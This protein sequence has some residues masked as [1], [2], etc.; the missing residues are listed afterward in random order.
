LPNIQALSTPDIEYVADGIMKS[1]AV[2]DLWSQAASYTPRVLVNDIVQT[3]GVDYTY[4]SEDETVNFTV[5]PLVQSVIKMIGGRITITVKNLDATVP[6]ARLSVLPGAGTLFDDIGFTTYSYVQTLRSP[7]PQSYA[8]FGKSLFISDSTVNLIVGAPDA[9]AISI[10]TFDNGTTYFDSRSTGFADIVPQSGAV[11]TFDLLPSA[12]SSITNPGKFV[13]GQQLYDT[14]ISSLDQFGTAVDYT[15]GVLLIGSPGE[16]DGDSGANYGRIAEFR[17]LG[18]QPAWVEIRRQQP[19]VNYDLLNTVFMYD[20]VAGNVKQYFDFFNPLQGRLLGAVRQNLDYIGAIDPAAYNVGGINNYGQKWGFERVGQIWWDTTEARFIDPNQDDIVYASRRWGQLFP[21]SSVNVYQWVSSDVPPSQYQGPGQVRDPNSYVVISTLTPQGLFA[22]TYFFWVTGIRT[23]DRTAKKTL[24]IDTLTRYIENPRSSGIAYVAPLDASTVA[25]YNALPYI[26]AQDTILHIE[27]DV[28]ANQDAVHTEYQLIAQGR[29]D[30]FLSAGLYRKLQDSFCGVDTVGNLVPDPF[31]KPSES[32]GVEF[33][34]RQSMFVNRFLALQN[35]LTRANAI[36]TQFPITESRRFD[37]LKSQEPEPSASSGAWNKRVANLEELSFQNLAI[38]PEGY[39]Y[40]VVSDSSNNGLWTIYQVQQNDLDEKSL[41]L[42]RVQ[43]YDTNLYWEYVDWY[44]PGYSPSTVI[45]QEV[46]NVSALETITVPEGSS[47]KVTNNAQ[48]R[49]EVY[50]R[51]ADSWTRV[52][53]EDGTIQIKESIWNYQANSARFGF[54]IE[55]FDAQYF[56][57][58]PV[59]ETRKI[60]QSLNE[61]IFIDDLAI[62]RNNLLILMFN[63]IMQEQQA[64]LWLT[65][66]S[67]IDVDHVIRELEP[68]QIYRRDNQDFVEKYIEEVKPYHTQIREFNLIYKGQDEYLGSATD[69]DLPAYWDAKQGI[70]VSPVLDNSNPPTLST[71][72]SLPSTAEI[73]QTFPYNQ[74]YQ[75]YLQQ[76]VS[77]TVVD[78]GV[79]YT[80]APEVQVTGDA[81][82]Q[83][84]LVARVNSAGQV[85]AID[86]IDPGQGY[87][88]TPVIT[89]VGGNGSGAIAVPVMGNSLIRNINT[90]IKYDRYQYQSTIVD[91]QPNV[92]YDIGT[93]VRFDNRVWQAIN[94]V[95]SS[96]FEL[97]QWTLV[98]A[99]TLSG[100]DR[101]MGLY[102]PRANEPGLDLSQLISG[103]SY[104]GVQVDAPDF[105][106]NTGFDVGNFDINPFDNISFGP[107]GRPTYDPAILDAIYESNFADPYLGTLPAPA[108]DG[109][110]P[111]TGPNPIVVDGGEFVDVFSSH[112][113][114]ELVPGAIFDTLDLRVY[115][116]AGADWIGDGHGFNIRGISYE[117]SSTQSAY[118]FADLMEFPTEIRVWNQTQNTELTVDQQFSIDW[119]NQTVQILGGINNGQALRIRVYGLGGGNQIYRQSYN[120]A[121]IGSQVVIPVEFSLINEMVVFVNGQLVSNYIYSIHDTYSTKLI[122]STPLTSSQYVYIVAMGSEDSL[123]VSWSTPI[124]QIEIADGSTLSYPLDNFMGGTNQANLIVTKNGVRARPPE[125]LQVIADGSSLTYALPNRGGYNLNLVSDNE[126]SVYINNQSLVLGVDFVVDPA[127]SATERTITLAELPAAG[128]KILISVSTRADYYISSNSV[129]IWRATSPLIPLLGDIIQIISFN[130]TYQQDIVTEVFVGPTTRGTAITVDYDTTLYDQG[131]PFA[132]STFDESVGTVILTNRFD[133]GR[134]LSRTGERIE[135]Y[136]NG[137]RYFEDINYVIEGSEVIIL[138]PPIGA[139]DVVAVTLYANSIV[140]G[141]IAF[142]I[143]QDMRGQQTSYRITKAETT[144]LTQALSATADTIYVESA[145]TLST[146][147]LVNGIFG[148]ITV[149]GERIT[150][151]NIDYTNNT[152]SGLRRGTAGT[153]ADEHAAGTPVYDTNIGEI[154]PAQY[155]DRVV[156]TNILADGTTTTFVTEDLD[157]S[158]LT[159]T[160]IDRA[161]MVYVGGLYQD[162]GYTV[163]NANPVT[164]TFTTPPTAGYQVS[165]R[166]RQGLSWY[167]P[168]PFT[169]SDGVAL[170]ETDTLAARFIRDQ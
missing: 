35:Y 12:S 146:P 159:G 26:S 54:D 165:I 167:Q 83:A 18:R 60:I 68:F 164:V 94:T 27:Y 1:F 32:Y 81:E 50:R 61:E 122:F 145:A 89:L 66:T 155:Q 2:G 67:L 111:D 72:S 170:Q 97:D 130:D 103:V 71:T 15:T 63:F 131:A 76:L 166:A 162:S 34:P 8:H 149:G 126:V 17:N 129:L 48:G 41:F 95:S 133:T 102:V 110:P 123:S 154:L 108:Y 9:S 93:Q 40:L 91:W 138:G 78:G 105:N 100:V 5:A 39:L 73:W 156:A 113:P 86:V 98:D 144:A 109:N 82:V 127:I 29:A 58:E 36:M 16:D 115:T 28:E 85:A 74:W 161:V 20:R 6:L 14:E 141:E 64:P 80:I 10:T 157:L 143:F 11:Y 7:V 75:N 160:E 147:N 120:G 69:F 106:Q 13:F 21:G 87:L 158:S 65:K 101:T 30:G 57:Q 3:L 134:D 24:S 114:E 42:V 148:V 140:P 46:P 56:D 96:V 84:T 142:R 38:V 53:V 168:G 51:E 31:L 153:A 22:S 116:T 55:V 49:F 59:Q 132:V 4:D 43:T 37:L 92:T 33:R 52:C 136:F 169:P 45:F 107:E 118:S 117:Y 121:D 128:T 19:V 125:G 152:V 23:V 79:G 119:I 77:V 151:R 104:P 112:A 99:A 44:L 70:F 47:V 25:I 137:L 62:E 135:V 163:S 88:T 90:V 124:K 139:I 150:Y